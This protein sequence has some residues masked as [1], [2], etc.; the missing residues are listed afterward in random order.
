MHVDDGVVVRRSPWM[1]PSYETTLT[2]T[3]QAFRASYLRSVEYFSA[4]VSLFTLERASGDEH[5]GR[6]LL[7]LVERL[8]FLMT[9]LCHGKLLWATVAARGEELHALSVLRDDYVVARTVHD[10]TAREELGWLV[11][12][13][14]V[15]FGLPASRMTGG[16]RAIGGTEAPEP[17]PSAPLISLLHSALS[18][19]GIHYVGFFL[20]GNLI[21]SADLFEH[22]SLGH[23]A[24]NLPRPLNA[25]CE[26]IGGHLDAF[27]EQRKVDSLS[28]GFE[29][30]Q[31]VYRRVH[32]DQ[33]VV[34]VSLL[35]ATER[36]GAV[37]RQIT[38]VLARRSVL[39]E[40]RRW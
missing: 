36:S 21:A 12:T 24:H 30:R 6:K 26:F 39:I 13:L 28:L 14:R 4:G 19:E 32:G 35:Q 15:E 18:P 5:A 11:D 3:R 33:S 29:D 22:P 8:E 1:S 34:G 17:L 16:H 10:A 38:A 7:A 40:G 27:S 2:V 31:V 9:P 37:D 25:I 20:E 23:M